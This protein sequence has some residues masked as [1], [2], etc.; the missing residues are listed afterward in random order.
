MVL[1]ATEMADPC[2]NPNVAPSAGAFNNAVMPITP[3]PPGRLSTTTDWPHFS[4][5]FTPTWRINTSGAEPAGNGTTKRTGWVGHLGAGVWAQVVG[6]T[7][8]TAN[9]RAIDLISRVV[10][11]SPSSGVGRTGLP[12]QTGLEIT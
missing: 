5:N 8:P 3:L 9:A 11:G 10:M 1:G 6:A 12:K 4:V 7:Q 2:T